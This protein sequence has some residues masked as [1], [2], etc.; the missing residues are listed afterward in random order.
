MKKFK[1]LGY[2]AIL[3]ILIT[4]CQKE[5][6]DEDNIV[7]SK[8][9]LVERSTSSSIEYPTK[10]QLNSAIQAMVINA[11]LNEIGSFVYQYGL[12]DWDH[13]RLV[14]KFDESNYI[15]SVPTLYDDYVTSVLFVSV[16][17]DEH[18]FWHV[19][20]DDLNRD[21]EEIIH[22]FGA[23]QALLS[24]AEFVYHEQNIGNYVSLNLY[25]H[26]THSQLQDEINGIQLRG[27]CLIEIELNQ[28]LEL[29]DGWTV[30]YSEITGAPYIKDEDGNKIDWGYGDTNRPGKASVNGNVINNVLIIHIWAW[31]E[32]EIGQDPQSYNWTTNTETPT[33]GSGVGNDKP[34]WDYEETRWDEDDRECQLAFDPKMSQDIKQLETSLLENSCGE[35]ARFNILNKIDNIMKSACEKYYNDLAN[36]SNDEFPELPNSQSFS[37]KITTVLESNEFFTMG[38]KI[39]LVCDGSNSPSTCISDMDDCPVDSYES[40]VEEKLCDYAISSFASEYGLNLTS[41]EKD[42]ISAGVTS[43]GDAGFEETAINIL[44]DNL[45]ANL[46]ITDLNLVSYLKNNIS[47]YD[48]VKA[49]LDNI[50]VEEI[51]TNQLFDEIDLSGYGYSTSEIDEVKS[52]FDFQNITGLKKIEWESATKKQKISHMYQT[53]VVISK[54]YKLI[55]D[56]KYNTH[57]DARNFY[58]GP[59][60]MS[61]SLYDGMTDIET[62]I[63]GNAVIIQDVSLLWNLRY[64]V[65]EF[66]WIGL[67]KGN[68]MANTQHLYFPKRNS[69][70]WGFSVID[71]VMPNSSWTEFYSNFDY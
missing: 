14:N 64:D 11:D 27:Y 21:T 2:L 66:S 31:C 39:C 41:D 6:L 25:E 42:V 22:D 56:D 63:S 34:G 58:S 55:G 47:V 17:N 20:Y 62:E 33:P 19:S 57:Y 61:G 1:L 52:N 36:T 9:I 5:N 30:Y 67:N 50:C 54:I 71:F 13:A 24:I 45:V 37:N 3:G 4:S 7:D 51:A 32:D 28:S 8:E 10:V 43:C 60:T 16:K 53:L 46:D 18:F 35:A 12:F 65:D 49:C 44:V 26:L 38:K 23:K 40:C 48:N 69:T 29:Q 15:I 68:S 70:A 59:I